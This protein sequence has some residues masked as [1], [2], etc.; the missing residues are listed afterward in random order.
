[1]FIVGRGRREPVGAEDGVV[2]VA[3]SIIVRRGAGVGGRGK[4]ELNIHAFLEMMW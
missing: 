1:L 2:K 3:H 4:T